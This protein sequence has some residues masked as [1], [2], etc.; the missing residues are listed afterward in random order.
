M[1]YIKHSDTHYAYIKSK[2][3]DS[4]NYYIFFFKYVIIILKSPIYSSRIILNGRIIKDIIPLF[5]WIMSKNHSLLELVSSNNKNDRKYQF[6]MRTKIHPDF[7][8]FQS[9]KRIIKYWMK[10]PF[11]EGRHTT[12]NKYKIPFNVRY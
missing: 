1:C 5:C 12:E 6:K 4:E 8:T 10:F 3:N 11:T 7:P 2:A 9:T